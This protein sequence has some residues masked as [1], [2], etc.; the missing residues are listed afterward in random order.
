MAPTMA[1]TA[2][3]GLKVF[4]HWPSLLIALIVALIGLIL[5]SVGLSQLVK[6]KAKKAKDKEVRYTPGIVLSSVGSS[7]LAMAVGVMIYQLR[8]PID[9]MAVATAIL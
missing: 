2:T 6:V 4:S 1:T 9:M 5:A 3:F 7:M 8:K